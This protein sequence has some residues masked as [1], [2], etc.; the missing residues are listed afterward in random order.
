MAHGS[1]FIIYAALVGNALIAVT[2]FVAAGL[3]GSA[4][5]MAEGIHS[6]VDTGNQGLL[7]Y[8]LRRGRQPADERF[9]FGHGK[10]IYFWSFVVAIL[11]FGLGAGVSMYEGVHRVLHPEPITRP[12]VN[13]IVLAFAMLFEGAAWCLALR[14]FRKQQHGRGIRE[15]VRASKDPTTF[16]VLFEDTAALLGLVVAGVGLTLSQVLDLP[17]FDGIASI[18]I[19]CILAFT[20]AWLAKRTKS[21]LIGEAADPAIVADI[22]RRVGD[23]EAVVAVNEVL[24]LHMGPR[25][26]LLTISVDFFDDRPAGEI[27]QAIDQLTREIRAA[28]PTITRVFIEAE[29]STSP[30]VG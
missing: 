1:T 15:T 11:I 16:V 8:G 17:V 12:M 22:R 13:Y 3:T 18:G 28:H 10:E 29:A 20:A 9:P 26:V 30:S 5:M 2:K 4:A 25:Q 21:L 19:G 23:I 7:L 6:L 14:E 24:T 27:E